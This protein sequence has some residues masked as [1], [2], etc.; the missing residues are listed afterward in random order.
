MIKEIEELEKMRN[1]KVV[2]L[3]LVPHSAKL[4]S[5]RQRFKLKYIDTA[6]K[7]HRACFF[8]MGY[9]QQKK[10]ATTLKAFL[11]PALILLF[12]LS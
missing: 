6:Y 1:S 2:E 3:S 10:D 9:K 4:I 5:C 8:P 11:L 12:G 7:R